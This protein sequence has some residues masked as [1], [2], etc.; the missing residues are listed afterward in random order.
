MRDELHLGE[1]FQKSTSNKKSSGLKYS[2]FFYA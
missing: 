2:R 1:F